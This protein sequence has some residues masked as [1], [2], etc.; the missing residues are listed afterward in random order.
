MFAL[1]LT[2]CVAVFANGGTE[3]AG[4]WRQSKSSVWIVSSSFEK[5]N[6]TKKSFLFLSNGFTETVRLKINSRH[7]FWIARAKYNR[8]KINHLCFYGDVDIATARKELFFVN[9]MPR[10][11]NFSLTFIL[12]P[13]IH[14]DRSMRY[15]KALNEN[16]SC[17]SICDFSALRAKTAKDSLR[18]SGQ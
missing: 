1:I 6:E 3:V 5:E 9:T 18:N 8:K 13:Q 2:F 17:A 14:S 16:G 11:K 10:R 15:F 4:I 7:T 12:S